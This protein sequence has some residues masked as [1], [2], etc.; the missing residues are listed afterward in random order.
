M[1]QPATDRLLEYA[2]NR[3]KNKA[4]Q[5]MLFSFVCPLWLKDLC[6]DD[7]EVWYDFLQIS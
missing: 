2:N 6:H 3:W 5:Q 1:D 7:T 4:F